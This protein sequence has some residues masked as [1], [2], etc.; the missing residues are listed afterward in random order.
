MMQ[1]CGWK[2][3]RY[4][5]SFWSKKSQYLI[6]AIATSWWDN[7][8][9]SLQ[10]NFTIHGQSHSASLDTSLSEDTE[11]IEEAMEATEEIIKAMEEIM[12]AK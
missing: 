8:G 6:G 5:Y 3:W 11:A 2:W 7:H 1:L 12:E 10:Q 9:S 4:C